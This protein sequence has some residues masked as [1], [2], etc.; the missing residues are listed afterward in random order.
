MT[1]TTSQ[2][3][4]RNVAIIAHVD[5]GKTTL[6]DRLVEQSG[7]L[8]QNQALPECFMDSNDL[9]RERG[10]TILA[11][12]ISV[13]YND[14]KINLIDTPGHADFG[15]EVERVLGMADGVVLLV[16][17]AEGPMPQTRFV[18]R[19]ALAAGLLPILV[20]NKLDR[21][22]ARPT[23][24]VDEVFDLMVELGATDRQLDFPVLFASGRSGWAK[25]ELG[26]EQ[27]NLLPLFDAI[28]ERVPAPK[29]DIEGP[30]QFQVMSLE[31]NDFTGRVAIG[32]VHRG[33]MKPGQVKLVKRDGSMKSAS[34]K[35]V[36]VFE[37]L[38][39]EPRPAVYCGDI[40]A[41]EGIE[42]CDIGDTIADAL[43]PE[44][45]PPVTVDEPTISMLFSVNDGPFAGQAGKYVTSRQIRDRLAKELLRNVALR[46]EDTD[47]PEVL[48]VYGRGVLHLGVLIEN[49]RREGFELCVAKPKV[50]L[51]E[52]DGERCEPIETVNVE[53]PE[54]GAGKIIE[55]LGQR[56]GELVTMET[57]EGHVM[58]EFRCP[59]RGLIGIR[60][61]A[62][63]LTAGEAQIH[64]VFSAYEPWKGDL[65]TRINGVLVSTDP[66]DA[67][68]YA[69]FKLKDR[70]TFF[71]N[72]QDK[73]YEGMVVG[74]HSKDNDLD[75]NVC[76]A[77]K[78]T[79]IR[80]TS[81][82]E[83]L[84]LPPPRRYTV[85]EALEYIEDDELVEIT[86]DAV[87]IRKAMLRPNDR[88]RMRKSAEA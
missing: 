61:K 56:R 67:N 43:R 4:I 54:S 18:T 11:K 80:T 88:E 73:V 76:R 68:A 20:V 66:G 26:D 22:D 82:D 10:I 60:T 53:V 72:P 59:S 30:L 31:Y 36:M 19:K 84:V 50:V 55:L 2:P 5:H 78:L 1:T 24:V 35:R 28:L 29:V 16:D 45:L 21:P 44:A 86:P 33:V 41:I 87:R 42:D 65:P 64:H 62:L 83:K 52:I 23:E 7:I 39:R 71:I 79:N 49:M 74:E 75:V 51:K 46:V 15:G 3:A 6:V 32:R 34:V 13:P 81:A 25:R 47:R 37:G 40:C 57:H 8:R 27:V 58:M 17:A 48:K 77:K 69:L 9:E 38:R 85:E 14:V 12:N 70:G 63:N